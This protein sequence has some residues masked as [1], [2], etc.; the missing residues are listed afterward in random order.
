MASWLE[1]VIQFLPDD[2]LYLALIA[3][4]AFCESIPLLGLAVPGSTLII[5]AGYLAVHGKG[6]LLGV[7]FASTIGAGGGDLFAYWLGGRLGQPLLNSRW[8]RRNR[9]TRVRAESFLR[10][11]GGKSLFYARFLGPIRGTVPFLAGV[12]QMRPGY[13]GRATLISALL[14]GLAYPGIGYLGGESWQRAS[15]LSSRFGLLICLAL[16]VTLFHFWLKRK[17]K[18]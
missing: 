18:S 4:I 15:S 1:Q 11:H 17:S 3:L 6:S 8:G 5:L 12:T 16:V 13:F 9:R 2:N 10:A 7:I 14:W